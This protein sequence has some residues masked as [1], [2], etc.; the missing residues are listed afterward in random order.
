M[1]RR[2]GGLDLVVD[3]LACPVCGEGLAIED[4]T[5]RC[6]NG[7]A[8]DIARQGYVSLTSG[9]ATAGDTPA[10]IEARERFLGA[11]H[12][13]AIVDAVVAA[14]PV[15]AR[16]VAVDVGGGT[17]YHLSRV[18]EERENL[19]GL[20]LDTSKPAIR[21]AA[22][23]HRRMAAAVAD[24][25]SGLPLRSGSV[26]LVLSIFA[27]RNA[28][29]SARILAPGGSLVVVTPTGRHL[30]ELVG[31]VGLVSVDERKEERLARQLAGFRL[32][33]RTSVEYPVS[34]DRRAA[35][36]DVLMGPTGH[37]ADEA[38]IAEAIAALADP[39]TTTVSVTVSVFRPVLDD[40]HDVETDVG[41]PR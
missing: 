2:A 37:H 30:A 23:A 22:R 25:W 12:Y 20:V 18:L 16:G 24:A 9:R 26:P 19:L 4:T 5:V 31:A 28:V 10:M 29:E 6:V 36:D 35:V 3:V 17:G 1:E 27:P 13:D 7:H 32:E 11:G 41:G 14:V 34:L 33:R 15:D 39:V 40:G 21:R 8:F 38:R